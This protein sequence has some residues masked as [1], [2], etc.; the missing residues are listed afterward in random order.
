M[1][2][3]VLSQLEMIRGGI[4]I[5]VVQKTIVYTI[6]FAQKSGNRL[7][8]ILHIS[9][10]ET[11]TESNLN[12]VKNLRETSISLDYSYNSPNSYEPYKA[13]IVLCTTSR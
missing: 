3:C 11:K 12:R 4:S 8:E 2:M 10:I 5:L 9:L 13:K 6:Q 1:Y 7:V